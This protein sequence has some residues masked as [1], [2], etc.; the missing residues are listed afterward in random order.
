MATVRQCHSQTV[1]ITRLADAPLAVYKPCA[2]NR[3]HVCLFHLQLLN[4]SLI[5][6]ITFLYSSAGR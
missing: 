3:L 2:I 4:V 5:V 6:K 1:A